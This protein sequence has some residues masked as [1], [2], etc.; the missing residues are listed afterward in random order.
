MAAEEERRTW[1]EK[2]RERK[3]GER[4]RGKK[5]T[6][7]ERRRRLRALLSQ[8]KDDLM[9]V[10][11]IIERVMMA[12]M[13]MM[14]MMMMMERCMALPSSFILHLPPFTQCFTSAVCFGG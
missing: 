10:R 3:N 8:V 1:D 9:R 6:E 14:M 7:V 2:G 4:M 5:E 12:M 13:M 11:L